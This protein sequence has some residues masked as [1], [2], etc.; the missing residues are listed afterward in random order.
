MKTQSRLNNNHINTERS[1]DNNMT[2]KKVKKN[3][4]NEIEMVEMQHPH[5]SLL[6]VIKKMVLPLLLL[7]EE[8]NSNEKGERVQFQG[9]Q[10]PRGS[11]GG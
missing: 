6:Q 2:K 7:N 5:V 1:N 3:H 4:D 10:C 9:S 8:R 11:S